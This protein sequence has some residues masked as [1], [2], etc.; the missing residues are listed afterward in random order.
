MVTVGRTATPVVLTGFETDTVLFVFTFKLAEE[1]F[2]DATIIGTSLSIL[3]TVDTGVTAA[4]FPF[5]V[6]TVGILVL[7]TLLISFIYC[8]YNI[9]NCEDYK[10][11]QCN[12]VSSKIKPDSPVS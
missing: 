4:S 5:A 8:T 6:V 12:F 1:K 2:D 10:C 7:P 3:V 11:S 9:R